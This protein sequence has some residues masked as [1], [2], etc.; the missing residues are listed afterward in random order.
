[1]AVSLE[2]LHCIATAGRIARDSGIRCNFS[3]SSND[4]SFL[5]LS[6]IRKSLPVKVRGMSSI[7]RRKHNAK[8]S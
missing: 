5:P 7:M 4:K 3:R 6:E 8:D 1:M 2:A